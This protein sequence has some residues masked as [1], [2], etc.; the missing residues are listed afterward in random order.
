MSTRAPRRC[1]ASASRF[2]LVIP[3]VM[4]A[5]IGLTTG[6]G[7][8]GSTSQSTGPTLNGNTSVT[9]M[10]TSTAND[11]LTEFDLGFQGISLTSQ[12]G[13]T[14]SLLSSGATGAEFMHLNGLAEPLVTASI[15]Q[16]IYTSANV[17]LN[18]AAFVCVQLYSTGAGGEGDITTNTFDDAGMPASGITVTL[19][20]PITVTGE[21][22]GV[23]LDLL[24]SQSA[25]YSSCYVPNGIASFSITPA[26]NLALLNLS[27]APT[28]AANGKV[29]GVDGQ[30]TAI[31]EANSGFTL[32]SNDFEGSRNVS[33]NS[34]ANTVYQGISGF[35]DLKVGTFVDMDGAIQAN[36]TVLGTRI[37]VEDASAAYVFRGPLM[38]VTPSVSALLMHPNVE[39]GN[40]STYSIGSSLFNFGSAVFQVSGELTNLETLP[41][42]ASFDASNMVPGQNVYLSLATL[43]NSYPVI[44]TITLMPQTID[45]TVVSSS[46]VGAFTDYTVSLAPYDLFPMLAVLPGQTTIETD[47]SQ[48]E[49]YTDSNTQQMGTVLVPGSAFRF[50]GL[51]FNDN[52]TLRMDCAQVNN[53]V[54]FTPP[55]SSSQPSRMEKGVVHQQ[56]FNAGSGV[57]RT[58]S[59]ITPQ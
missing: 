31:D 33:V 4:L 9:V 43:N 29:V 50:Y 27:T 15:P 42:T 55:A 13:K 17:T 25:T 26:F 36:G 39:E 46:T 48:I 16:D 14:V 8:S 23:S 22:M 32:S 20:S 57:Q 44:D 37:A 52:G 1:R 21:S 24:V 11:Q 58:V 7:S 45:G 51:V 3:A 41:F 19:P 59:T 5:V 10:L 49:V 12:S 53:G 47:P 34:G 30:V 54:A 18:G 28:S 38:E 2:H 6:C 40:S 35:G 56:V